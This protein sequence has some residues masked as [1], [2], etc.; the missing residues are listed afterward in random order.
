[1]AAILA[2]PAAQPR[3]TV[4]AKALLG[5]GQLAHFQGDHD[6]ARTLLAE[7]LA[8]SREL[9]D[10]WVIAESLRTLGEVACSLGD[11]EAA[12]ALVEDS[13]EMFWGL[14][15]RCEIAYSL[16]VLGGVARGEGEYW[17]AADLHNV[18]LTFYREQ[19]KSEGLIAD[20]LRNLGHV[21]YGQGDIGR[22][23]ALFAES[24]AILG[25]QTYQ[26]PIPACLTGLA[27][28]AGRTGQPER[29]ARLLG[30]AAA[31][32]DTLGA[33]WPSVDRADYDCH[34]AATRA[35]LGDEA[36]ASAWAAGRAMTLEQACAEALAVSRP[37]ASG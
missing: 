33:V 37:V 9:G 18:S 24:L 27:G 23:A 12:R 11:Y 1:L 16:A 3:T 28:V 4:R 34:V 22:A 21:A 17:Q 10:R 7:S 8:I 25:E 19:G 14:R 29:A 31:L 20:N 15:N 26:P 6:T 30:A 5:A 35:E 13:V 32:L 2:L 36:F